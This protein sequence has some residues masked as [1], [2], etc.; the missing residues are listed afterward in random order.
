MIVRKKTLTEEEVK[1]INNTL[2]IIDISIYDLLVKRKELR[3]ALD[4][5]NKKSLYDL[6][7]EISNSIQKI[8]S[9][10]KYDKDILKFTAGILNNSNLYG[11]NFDIGIQIKKE[12]VSYFN[13]VY[14]NIRNFLN[15]FPS[16][17]YKAFSKHTDIIDGIKTN[18][19][20]LASIP[21]AK[22]NPKDVW[23]ISL[24]S[25]EQ[26]NI[27]IINKFPLIEDDTKDEDYLIGK[28]STYY[29]FDRSII[30]VATS[31]TITNNWLK[32][33]LHKANIPLYKIIDSTA[34][35]NGTVLHLIE[36][37]KKILSD[38]DFVFKLNETINGINIR[39][40]GYLGGYF[41][42][43]LDKDKIVKFQQNFN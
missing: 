7:T 33:A 29:G 1:E 10:R 39:F 21:S 28:T 38:Q 14:S 35:F 40:A 31:E 5:N 36:I 27:K 22:T 18:P 20:M 41:L 16:L 6:S 25:P 3:K 42:P 32:T 43:L 24:L 26:K 12:A 34:I 4:T 23:W 30:V 9:Q 8:T 17:N 15:F 37:S 13:K 11:R 19:N 2:D